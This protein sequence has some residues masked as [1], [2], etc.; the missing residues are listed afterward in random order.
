MRDDVPRLGF[1]AKIRHRYLFEIARE[2]LVLA[3]AGLRR[4]GYTPES[5]QLFCER[6]GVSKA[7]GWI[8]YSSL[9]AALRDHLEG[10]ARRAMAVLD[11]VKLRLTNWASVIFQDLVFLSGFVA[12][13]N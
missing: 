3:H 9:D 5:I 7:G 2:C 12:A 11:P 6:S 13:N 4:R 10:K 1:K 8:D